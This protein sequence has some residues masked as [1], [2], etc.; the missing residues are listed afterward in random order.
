M[1]VFGAP[2]IILKFVGIIGL[3][4]VFL[5]IMGKAS[6]EQI[7][8]WFVVSTVVYGEVLEWNTPHWR[9][10]IHLLANEI[11]FDGE[12]QQNMWNAMLAGGSIK[13]ETA[14]RLRGVVK[15]LIAANNLVDTGNYLGSIAIGPTR[16]EAFFQ[17][18]LRLLEPE[19]SVFAL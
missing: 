9:V 8:E 1:G 13:E 16:D 17:S 15:F 5:D 11:E 14:K 18:D 3:H 6:N 2:S 7:G 4:E 10:A 12:E 19:T